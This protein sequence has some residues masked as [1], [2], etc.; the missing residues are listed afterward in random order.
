VAN[1]VETEQIVSEALTTP[2]HAPLSRDA[3]LHPLAKDESWKP[4][5]KLNP[6]YTSYVQHRGSIPIFW[7]QDAT[8]MQAKPPIDRA[9]VVAFAAGRALT[10]Q[11][12][13]YCRSILLTRCTTLRRPFRTL[14]LP[15]HRPQLDQVQRANTSRVQ[16]APGTRPMHRIPQQELARRMQDRVHWFRHCNG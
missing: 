13:R 10:G 12:S 2:F 14:W 8:G 3:Q 16:A 6:R 9:P 15:R 11:H 4:S 5:V 7:T 1:D